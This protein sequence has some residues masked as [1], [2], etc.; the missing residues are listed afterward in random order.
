MKRVLFVLIIL[1]FYSYVYSNITSITVYKVGYDGQYLQATSKNNPVLHI[2]INDDGSGDVLNYFGVYNSLNS[3]YIGSAIEPDSIAP[4]SVKLWYYPVDTNQFSES[5]AT[6]VTYLPTDGGDWWHNDS[7][8]FSVVNGS[9][10]WVTVDIADSPAFG[11][12][13]FQTENISFQ[14]SSVGSSDAPSKPYVL[15]VTSVTPA[16]LLEIQHLPG[17]MQSFVSTGQTNIIPMEINFYNNS[18]ETAAD[19]SV[20]YVTITVKSYPPPGT[21]LEP[22][23]IISSIKIQDKQTGFIYGG[24]YSPNIAATAVPLLIPLAQLNIPSQTTVSA[25][26]VISITGTASAGTDFMLSL[27]DADSLNAYDYYTYKKVSVSH[28]FT[29]VFPMY[30]NFSK[31]QKKVEYINSFF[32]DSIPQNINK[33]ATNVELLKIRL[34]NPGD[35]LTATAELYNVKFYLQDASDNPIV[36]SSLFSKISV[37]DETGNIKYS[38]KTSSSIET[39]GNS[40]NFP[41]ITTAGI[42]AASSVTVVVRADISPVTVINNFKI[43]IENASDIT[44][45]D[46]N[47]LSNIS[48]IP[49]VLPSFTSVAL[50]SSSFRVSHEPKIPQMIYKNQKN[51]SIINITFKSPLSFGNGNILVAGI[52]LTAK[53]ASGQFVNFSD[54]VDKIVVNTNYGSMD[55]TVVPLSEKYYLS[56]PFPVTVTSAGETISLFMD[57]SKNINTNSIQILLENANDINAYQDN[58]PTREIFIT[59]DAGDSFPMSSGTGF[60]SGET[61][62]LKLSSYPNP[63]YFGNLCR[64]AYFLNGTSKVTI[65]IYDLM[66]NNIKTIID[67]VMKSSGSHNEDI[68][69]GTDNKGK[70]VL[71]GTYIVKM[72]IEENGNKKIIKDKI[73]L[74]K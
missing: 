41:F 28:S 35:T 66:G 68:W 38:V 22:S 12:I 30:S 19:I 16:Q 69:D 42:A 53:N 43:G 40:I 73:T 31:I 49:D 18:P 52:T 20:N 63:F 50:L 1:I 67:N 48:V 17:T 36:P 10:F 56:F 71:A 23:S 14:N 9:G 7:L 8:S 33:G 29:D 26:V 4:G 39:T 58:D 70:N 15:L 64:F 72:E 11:S 60:I 54:C 2:K 3:W 55:F 61:T 74:L 6:Y 24:I 25:N 44:C 57:I 32:I 62:T 37:T 47:T 27:E 65:K 5:S 46:K 13:E 21:V 59:A 34:E 45:R 51:I